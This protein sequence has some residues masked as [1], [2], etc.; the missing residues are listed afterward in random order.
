[1]VFIESEGRFRLTPFYD[2]LSM[3]PA[4]DGRG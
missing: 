3:Y 1:M 4:F 2:I